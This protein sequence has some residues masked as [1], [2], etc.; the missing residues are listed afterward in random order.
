MKDLESP[1]NDFLN[2]VI[3]NEQSREPLQNGLNFSSNS[4]FKL[5]H[6]VSNFVNSICNFLK[7]HVKFPVDLSCVKSIISKISKTCF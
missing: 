6:F 3:T 1:I 4:E 5:N 2:R 7:I